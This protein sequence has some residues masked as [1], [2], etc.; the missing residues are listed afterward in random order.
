MQF[1]H[2]GHI[3]SWCRRELYLCFIQK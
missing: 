3:T 2:Y 1:V